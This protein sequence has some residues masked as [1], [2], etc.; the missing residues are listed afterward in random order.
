MRLSENFLLSEFA[1]KDGADFPPAVIENLRRL[2]QALEV[3]RA[4]IRTPIT[5]TSGYR[6]PAHNKAVKGAPNST[7][8]EGIAA[9]FRAVGMAPNAVAAIIERLISEGKIPQGG[10]KAYAT[11]VH[12]DIRGTRARW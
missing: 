4:T 8:I 9:D 1:S 10:L 11:W 5:I 12:Y 2:A 6:S 7:H 3:I